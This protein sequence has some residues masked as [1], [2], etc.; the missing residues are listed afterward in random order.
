M[1]CFVAAALLWSS[2][3]DA[4]TVVFSGNCDVLSE[5]VTSSR[6]QC[7]E[8]RG[9]QLSA[10]KKSQNGYY[11]I[12]TA[13]CRGFVPAYCLRS[14]KGGAK[15]SAKAEPGPAT[16][17]LRGDTAPVGRKITS[18]SEGSIFSIGLVGNF[19]LMFARPSAG[20]TGTKGNDFGGGLL[21]AVPLSKKIRITAI[22]M[23]QNISL[24]RTVDGGGAI[25]D[26]NPVTFSQTVLFAGASLMGGLGFFGDIDYQGRG[27]SWWWDLGVEYLVPLSAKQT[28]SLGT[29][30]SFS[31][32]DKLFF[33]VTGP[34]G[35]F[36][37]SDSLNLNA[38]LQ[39]LYNLGA[40]NGSQ[41]LGGRLALSFEFLL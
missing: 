36:G 4:A 28:D 27:E 25:A 11:E 34:S 20:A 35:Q 37:L 39:F 29:E 23:I 6:V 40:Q 22:P 18:T 41:L 2:L 1:K 32:Q 15:A 26:P 17:S 16:P 5:P 19:G 10:L 21:L 14:L 30:I 33:L 7:K 13:A 24:S 38:Y 31:T 3:G 9:S 12:E 8:K